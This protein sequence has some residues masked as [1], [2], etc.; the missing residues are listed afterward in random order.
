[1]LEQG[2][3]DRCRHATCARAKPQ[4]TGASDGM[5][6]PLVQRSSKVTVVNIFSLAFLITVG[7]RG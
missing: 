5:R 6:L 1:V 4:S 2:E 3:Q 7:A